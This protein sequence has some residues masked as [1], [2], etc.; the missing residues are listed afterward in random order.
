MTAV[1]HTDPQVLRGS[2]AAP[3]PTSPAAEP[4]ADAA[5]A[6]LLLALALLHVRRTLECSAAH[7]S[8][9]WMCTSD[10]FASWSFLPLHLLAA[11]AATMWPILTLRRA[12]SV[13]ALKDACTQ[14]G[15]D[16]LALKRRWYSC[17]SSQARGT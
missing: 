10:P 17:P 9:E 4:F 3:Q 15:A 13:R 11:A 5:S 14:K 8:S 2:I 6:I 1:L 7:P 16:R 12:P